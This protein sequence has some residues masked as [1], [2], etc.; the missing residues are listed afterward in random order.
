VNLTI[1]LLIPKIILLE[2]PVLVKIIYQVEY[3]LLIF[4]HTM[5]LDIKIIY[6]LH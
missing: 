5:F 2:L 6:Y 1:Y 3:I 4:M